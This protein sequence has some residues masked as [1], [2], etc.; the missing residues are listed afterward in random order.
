M[1][2]QP[3]IVVDIERIIAG[4]DELCTINSDWIERGYRRCGGRAWI[5][6]DMSMSVRL[7]WRKRD[8]NPSTVTCVMR[9]VVAP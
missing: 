1:S 5:A 9:G 3:T 4:D 6:R 8:G 7:V 2:R